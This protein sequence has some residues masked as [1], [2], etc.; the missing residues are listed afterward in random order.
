VAT[1]PGDR[2]QRK[3]FTESG[4]T[5][6]AYVRIEAE[7]DVNATTI[8]YIEHYV[9]VHGGANYLAHVTVGLVKEDFLATKLK[10]S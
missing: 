4:G 5:A 7:P 10:L 6:D 1:R 3:P 8:D 9:P 2:R